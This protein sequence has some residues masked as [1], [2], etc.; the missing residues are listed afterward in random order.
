MAT[1]GKRR[2][3]HEH[4]ER[5]PHVHYEKRTANVRG[6]FL[7]VLAL[8]VLAVLIHL[9]VAGLFR[10]FYQHYL[11]RD[12]VQEPVQTAQPHRLPPEP[13]LQPD[14]YSDLGRLRTEED[15]I[16]DNYRWVDQKSGVVRIPVARAIELAAKNGLPQFPAA[17]PT[18]A[19]G[20]TPA[21]SQAAK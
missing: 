3:E 18:T 14:E 16:L 13:R 4:V 12:V 20:T 15:D 9:A 10:G 5:N 19:Q 2:P 17:P 6:I 11:A 1:D 21:A 7:S 8:L